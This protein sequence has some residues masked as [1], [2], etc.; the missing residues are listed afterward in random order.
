MD[1]VTDGSYDK[2]AKSTGTPDSGGL[3]CEL[4][5]AALLEYRRVRFHLAC[6]DLVAREMVNGQGC[7]KLTSKSACRQVMGFYLMRGQP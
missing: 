3:S 7:H 6:S 4:L 2:R 1:E 5:A